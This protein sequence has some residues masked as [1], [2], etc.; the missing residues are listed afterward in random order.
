MTKTREKAE[1]V[2]A[3][4]NEVKQKTKDQLAKAKEKLSPQSQVSAM[5]KSF[6]KDFKTLDSKERIKRIGAII[7]AATIGKLLGLKKKVKES[8]PAGRQGEK[9]ATAEP[10]ES[11]E[12]KEED[13]EAPAADSEEP[14]KVT[15]PKPAEPRAASKLTEAAKN[16][17]RK[18]ELTTALSKTFSGVEIQAGLKPLET[19]IGKS[20]GVSGWKKNATHEWDYDAAGNNDAAIEKGDY[21]I[22]AINAPAGYTRKGT[23]APPAGT[24]TKLTKIARALR[25]DPRMPL[26]TGIAMTV[27]G[28]EVMM[29]KEIHMHSLRGKRKEGLSDYFYQPHTGVSYIMKKTS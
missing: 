3:K 19:S 27:D 25:A 10:T 12:P 14:A 22:Q 7:F 13:E 1:G 2:K 17:F 24:R 16:K 9:A 8:L 15:K 18:G 6:F 23:G 28:I 5:I 29:V 4:A 20:K 21:H 11:E 26:F